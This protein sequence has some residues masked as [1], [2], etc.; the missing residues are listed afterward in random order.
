M[1]PSA[2]EREMEIHEKMADA[3]EE[4]CILQWW[5][6]NSTALP[7]LSTLARV[8]LAIPASASKSERVFSKA[9]RYVT[10]RRPL[11]L[12]PECVEDQVVPSQN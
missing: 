6:S 9:G 4:E 2:L 5:S 7:I 11:L 10:P 3:S 1:T 8:V 12:L